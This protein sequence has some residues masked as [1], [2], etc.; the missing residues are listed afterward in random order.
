MTTALSDSGL[1]LADN[2]ILVNA[3]TIQGG[4]KNLQLNSNGTTSTVNISADSLTLSSSTSQYI[5]LNSV[6]LTPTTGSSGAN[7]LDTGSW[8]YSTWYYVFV[9]NGTSGTA[10]LF[11]LSATAPTL[12]SGYTYFARVGAIRIQS[13]TSY[14]PLAFKQY[15]RRVQYVVGSTGNMLGMPQMG[16]GAAG[17]GIGSTTAT[18][19][20]VGVSVFV[21]PTAAKI[22][23]I[24]G[25]TGSSSAMVAPNTNYGG[26]TST[27][28]PPPMTSRAHW[29]Q[30]TDLV[31]ES[32]NIYWVSDATSAYLYC[33][34]WEDN[35]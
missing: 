1:Q 12:P 4:F 2:S 23:L 13:A 28:N 7:G 9:I 14:Y 17:T 24:S 11:S 3:A 19:A 30:Q 15:G 33:N 34:G 35:L 18:W 27:T 6:I 5:R 22:C 31:L 8:A 25:S 32:A 16:V 29:W 26:D 21:P 10:G 20:A